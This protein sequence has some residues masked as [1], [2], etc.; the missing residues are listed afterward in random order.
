MNKIG[1]M[2]KI[3]YTVLVLLTFIVG[4]LYFKASYD[5]S[6]SFPFTQEIILIILGSIVTMIITAALLNRQTE[7]EL[8]K[9]QRLRLFEL[10]SQFYI[11]LLNFV[12]DILSSHTLGK[13]ER[14]RLNLLTHKLS[15]IASPEVLE[16]YE[17]FLD[18]L[19]KVSADV[20]ITESEGE[21]ISLEFSKLCSRIRM[22]M[23]NGNADIDNDEFVR[24]ESQIMKN[25]KKS[26]G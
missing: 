20:N 21:E 11:D 8:Q 10:K 14:I 3:I 22:D 23:L 26:E 12:E 19:N 1:T 16:Q 7:V 5:I 18:V 6:G 25:A 2:H 9:E 13:K 4:F 24:I 17:K 15:I